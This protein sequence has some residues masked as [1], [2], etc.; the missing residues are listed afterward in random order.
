MVHGTMEH[1]DGYNDWECEAMRGI[2][3]ISM[4]ATTYDVTMSTMS[5]PLA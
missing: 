5:L 4:V 2:V 1:G 3:V